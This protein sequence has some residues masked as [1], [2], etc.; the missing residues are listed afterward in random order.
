M[1]MRNG[2]RMSGTKQ[3]IKKCVISAQAT[4]QPGLAKWKTHAPL[5]PVNIW[6]AS[7]A[8]KAGQ[9]NEN[10]LTNQRKRRQIWIS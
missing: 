8:G 4:E 3:V 5:M 2:N 1:S 6:W 9:T 10:Q 7:S